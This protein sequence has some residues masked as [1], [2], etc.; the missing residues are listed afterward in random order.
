MKKI[1][2]FCCIMMFMICGC[3]NG[4][5]NNGLI[6]YMDAKEKIINNGAILLDVRTSDEYNQDHI[7]GAILLDVN[8]INEE[9]VANIID[10]FDTEIIVYCQS[11]NRSSKAKELLNDLGYNNV[12]DLGSID[13]WE[14]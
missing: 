8:N 14:E 3:S 9:E 6:S 1:L 10:S 2:I 7:N 5:G 12:Y 11:G 13:N 4:S